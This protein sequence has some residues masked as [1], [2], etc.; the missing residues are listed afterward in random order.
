MPEH[1]LSPIK[2]IRL[3]C[4]KRQDVR[5]CYTEIAH[6]TR[7]IHE[8]RTP[9]I[10]HDENCYFHPNCHRISNP[11]TTSARPPAPRSESGNLGS[12][13]KVA[14]PLAKIGHKQGNA[15]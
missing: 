6:H 15:T 10:N 8:I 4:Q 9:K 3:P 2:R 12:T 13:L 5:E 14:R 7:R 11:I 1:K